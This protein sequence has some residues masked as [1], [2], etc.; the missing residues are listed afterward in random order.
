VVEVTAPTPQQLRPN[1]F[2]I[3]SLVLVVASWFALAVR[4]ATDD[5]L[6]INSPLDWLYVCT[7]PAAVLM[8][9]AGLIA[10]RWRGDAWLAVSAFFA[11]LILPAG[12]AL[13]YALGLIVVGGVDGG[14]VD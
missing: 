5:I 7:V 13:L 3:G 10:I 1:W 9:A 12:Y 8:G 11:S 14:P 4:I 6:S 2:A